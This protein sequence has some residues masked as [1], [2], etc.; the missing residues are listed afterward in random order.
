MEISL[1]LV[2]DKPS[3]FIYGYVDLIL[4]LVQSEE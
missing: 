2:F 3:H 4:A 1:T